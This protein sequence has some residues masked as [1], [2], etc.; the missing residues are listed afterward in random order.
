MGWETPTYSVPEMPDTL[1]EAN[2]EANTEAEQK[3]IIAATKSGLQELRLS[4]FNDNG[5][6]LDGEIF[7]DD[8]GL[9]FWLDIWWEWKTEAWNT[10]DIDA[11][12]NHY[13]HGEDFENNDF[14]AATRI[15][16][17]S[18]W[19]QT[20]V[21]SWS[22]DVHDVRVLVG[23]GIQ[24]IWDLGWDGIQRAWHEMGG[25][26]ENKSA[27]EGVSWNTL[28][29]RAQ[30]SG[31]KYFLWEKGKGLHITGDANMI[32]PMNS[33]YGETRFQATVWVWAEYGRWSASISHT[34]AYISWP[35]GSET[36]LWSL[37]TTHRQYTSVSF[38]APVPFTDHTSFVVKWNGSN[39]LWQD[40]E[41][42]IEVWLE[43]KL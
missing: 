41:Q 4:T 5:V 7:G 18:I 26:Y 10:Y 42:S 3:D 13:T 27:Y 6:A 34:N 21:A 15:D 23:G 1:Q 39:A 16:H 38:T 35:D 8:T 28:D 30:V 9:S 22:S 37:D 33:D 31:D 36:I 12:W 24:A 19:V 11:K 43:W 20:E 29:F 2:T 14:S 25:W 17:I 40:G 32:L